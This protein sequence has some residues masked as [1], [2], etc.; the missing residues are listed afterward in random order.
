MEDQ[1]HIIENLECVDFVFVNWLL[2]AKLPVLLNLAGNYFR[3][4]TYIDSKILYKL[5]Y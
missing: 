2:K 3:L 4:S 5:I 1:E